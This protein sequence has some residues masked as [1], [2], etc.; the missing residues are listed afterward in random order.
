M[1]DLSDNKAYR[2]ITQGRENHWDRQWL[3]LIDL[4]FGNLDPDGPEADRIS[5]QAAE[6]MY[7]AK[8]SRR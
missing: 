2:R 8:V 1:S 4:A 6:V 3:E 7:R 5:A